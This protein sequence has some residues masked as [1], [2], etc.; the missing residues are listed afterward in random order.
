MIKTIIKR[1]G[2]KEEFN[3]EKL[4]GWGIWAASV[5][6]KSVNWGDVVLSAVSTLPETCTAEQLQD[7]LIDTC[8]SKRTWAYNRMAGRLYAATIYK[9]AFA[10]KKL[11]LTDGVPHV[12]DLH[13][14]MLKKGILD[15]SFVKSW[16]DEEYD[17]INK[18]IK[19]QLDLT[20][21]FYQI[22]QINEK[23]SL[24]DRTKKNSLYE[25]PQFVYMRVAMR[26]AMNKENRMEH[27]KKFYKYFAENKINIPTPYFTNA[28]TSK[29]GYN[30][31]C[32]YKTNDEV[33]SLAAG[34]HIAYTMTYSSAGIGSYIQTRAEGSPIRGGII[35]HRG[36]IGYYRA[37]VGA[38]QAN[39]QNGRGGA[40]TVTYD[41]YDPDV[42]TLQPLKNSMTPASKQVRGVDYAMAFNRFFVSKAARNE[43]IALFD[44]SKA[45]EVYEALTSGDEKEF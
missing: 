45:P 3:S 19:H 41:A 4:N 12:K 16:T 2:R 40:A 5:L 44:I 8:L 26:M 7:A 31:C 43:D 35:E 38:I 33:A 22:K 34:D 15:K 36:K 20:Y 10:N 14:L 21:P 25:T 29:N 42:L 9:I 1:D 28:G 23:Y 17:A 11:E 24:K 32:V 30:S 13:N 18:M 27:I 6:G 37:L 39:M